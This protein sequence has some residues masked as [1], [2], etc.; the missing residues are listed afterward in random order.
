MRAV[1]APS[2]ESKGVVHVNLARHI[3]PVRARDGGA[4]AGHLNVGTKQLAPL[5]RRCGLISKWFAELKKLVQ[6]EPPAADKLTEA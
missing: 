1:S 3:P 4:G 2:D 6:M 5:K